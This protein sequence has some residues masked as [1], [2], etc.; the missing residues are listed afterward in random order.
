ML[1]E[2][3]HLLALN[4]PPCLLTTPD[5]SDPARPNLMKLLHSAIAED[6]AW[7]KERGL[8]Y[9][10]NVHRL[11]FETSGVLLLAK[12]KPAL[13]Q[14]ADLFRSGKVLET[15]LALLPGTPPHPR[16]EVD[17]PIGPD[18]A[19]PGLMRVTSRNGKRSCTRFEV[20]EQF[21]GFT[22]VQCRPL[23]ARTHQ[24]RVHLKHWG[25]PICGDRL[26]GG[27]PLLL[28]QLKP[29][30]RLKPGQTERPLI[31]TLALHAESLEISHP[32]TAGPVVIRADWPK[33]LVVA[34]KYL[35]RYSPA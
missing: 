25:L 19:R 32:L 29:D 27:R 34:V 9:L 12:T 21:R 17:A 26:Y 7:A 35:R 3:E 8:A 31:S 11:D 15:Y 20:R 24:I 5:R 6:K 16:W 30:Y 23:A 4:K 1:F 2:D 28:S 10:A 33:D 13:P 18:P 14:L 22:L